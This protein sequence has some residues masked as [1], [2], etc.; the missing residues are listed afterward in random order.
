MG[1]VDRP[2]P[3]HRLSGLSKLLGFLLWSGA[4]MITYDTRLLAF[5]LVLGVLLFPMGKITWREVR[6]PLYFMLFF[7]TLNNVA[8]FLFSPLEGVA[9]YGSRHPLLH[10]FGPYDLT[11]EQLFY[12]LNITLKYLA[13]IPAALIFL[14]TTHPSELASSL[15]RVGVP[16][17]VSYSVAIA[18]RYFPDLQRS[19]L[20]IARAQ[21]ARGG[22]LS[23][24]ISWRERFLRAAGIIWPLTVSSLEKVETISSAMDLRGFGKKKRRTWYSARPLTLWDGL[25]ILL[26][27]GFFL[28]ALYLFEVNGG[29][30]Y[31]PF[32]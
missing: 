32:G 20:D 18:L 15:N 21:E 29:R 28:L 7:L 9:I 17:R 4:A 23:A 31:N 24:R 19:Y 13:V 3:L 27:A 25:A 11:E 22:E 1:Y 14:L 30:F 5:L 6:I 26:T 8:I 2:S 12:Q 10:L 16:Y